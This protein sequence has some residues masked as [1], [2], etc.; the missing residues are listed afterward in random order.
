MRWP[1]CLALALLTASLGLAADL[2]TSSTFRPTDL[3]ATE[4]IPDDSLE[5]AADIQ[6][7]IDSVP[8]P[9]ILH[10]T[11]RFPSGRDKVAVDIFHPPGPGTFPVVLLFHGAHPKRAEKHYLRM[12]EDL[13]E[14][15]YM[16][17]YVRYYERGRRGRGCRSQWSAT[18]N[19]AVTF[20]SG[21][22]GAD[23]QRVAVVGYSLGAFL[24]LGRAPVDERIRAVVAYYGGISHGEPDDLGRSMPPTLLLHGTADRIVPVRRSVDAFEAI[25]REG[26]NVDLVVYPGV[27][28]GFCLNGRGGPDGHAAQDA[29]NRTLAFLDFQ[30]RRPELLVSPLPLTRRIEPTMCTPP[31]PDSP[32]FLSSTPGYLAPLGL[33]S[34]AS[35]AL[36]NPSRDEVQTIVAA[37]RHTAKS[38]RSSH[39]RRDSK[40][41]VVP[42]KAH[43]R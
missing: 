16:S 10:R 32:P 26:R 1:A 34:S 33:G 39:T 41:T 2:A 8:Q 17:L 6:P 13:A 14:K 37:S 21:L 23:S 38:H 18:V 31:D 7:F 11:D 35:V 4:T 9:S 20:A 36:I 24:T 19:D 40:R 28:H 27:R 25:R 3:T 12:A 43:A 15:G 42:A 29:W 30:L 5:R 22:E